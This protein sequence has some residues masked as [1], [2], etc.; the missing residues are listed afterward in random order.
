MNTKEQEVI[1]AGF[2]QGFSLKHS[3]KIR[4][5]SCCDWHDDERYAVVAQDGKFFLVHEDSRDN[6]F[7]ELGRTELPPETLATL[8]YHDDEHGEW[9]T[10]AAMLENQ[11]TVTK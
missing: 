3:G 8:G 5:F 6:G 7:A 11:T 1:G 2:Q 10:L 4:R 9:Q